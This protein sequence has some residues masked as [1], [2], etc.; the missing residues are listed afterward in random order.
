MVSVHFKSCEIR[1]AILEYV[2]LVAW[3]RYIDRLYIKTVI[4]VHVR[5][6]YM[7]QIKK[8]MFWILSVSKY[9]EMEIKFSYTIVAGNKIIVLYTL[10][11]PLQLEQKI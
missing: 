1:S 4:H 5:F 3:S 11:L 9:Y 10:R 8:Y 6:L 2:M 7:L